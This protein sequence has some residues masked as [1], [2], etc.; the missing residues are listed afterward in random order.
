VRQC[1]CP[2]KAWATEPVDL[3]D[4]D[5]GWIVRGEQERAHL[6]TLLAPWLV[7]RVEHVGSTAIPELPA[8]PIIDLHLLRP[9]TT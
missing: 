7:G 6:A 8:K 2:V 1:G 9:T 3:V 5:P 4:A